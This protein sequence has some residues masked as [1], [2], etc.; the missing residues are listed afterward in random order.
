MKTQTDNLRRIL[1]WLTLIVLV[2]ILYLGLWPYN[3]SS[4]IGAHGRAGGESAR[5]SVLPP[6]EVEWLK[7]GPGL[8]F[9][10]YGSIFSTADFK[11]SSASSEGCALEI[12]LEP[13]LTE[14][15]ATTL[16]FS[17]EDNPLQFRLRQYEDSLLV[18]HDTLDQK[19]K[20]HTDEVSVEHVF[21]KHQR[22]L[23]TLSSGANGMTVYVNGKPKKSREGFKLTAR[24]F[25]GRLVFGDSPVGHESWG[26]DLR[27]LAIYPRELSAE[28]VKKNYEVW[29][30]GAGF[31]ADVAATAT[32]L[33]LFEEGTG[34]VTRSSVVGAPDLVIPA[35]LKTLRPILLRPFWKEYE[36]GWEYWADVLVNILAFVPFGFSFYGYLTVAG[37]VNKP[38]WKTLAAGFL[39]SLTI[40]LG[41]YFLP[42]RNSGTTDLI[43]NTSGAGLGALLFGTKRAR[44]ILESLASK[45]PFASRSAGA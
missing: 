16:A 24:N 1:G 7:N 30:S 22:L 39:M 6:N 44:R 23:I 27:G 4:P 28:R 36:V 42:M 31:P 13:A 3:F 37:G 45:W 10:D 43:T 29:S 12:W 26:G 2:L 40:E 9:G 34:S 32:A 20:T 8:H 15:F 33:Y 41:Q 17:T 25:T 5:W 19:H 14:G 38:L 18:S 21:R 11:A 35:T